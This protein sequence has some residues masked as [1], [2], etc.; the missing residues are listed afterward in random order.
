[1]KRV[2]VAYACWSARMKAIVAAVISPRAN[3]GQ[4]LLGIF[5]QVSNDRVSF[6]AQP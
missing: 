4:P 1:M 5:P 6:S 2:S 3:R